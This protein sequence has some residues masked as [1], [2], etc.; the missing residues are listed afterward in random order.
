MVLSVT[1][2][3]QWTSTP[4]PALVVPDAVGAA[5]AAEVRARLEEAGYTRY[6]L[7][8]RGSYERSAD[9]NEWELLAALTG[10]A[11]EVTGRQLRLS[12]ARALRLHA[13][14][15]LLVRHD[16]VYEGSPVEI[17]LDL[18]RAPVAGADV[19]YRHRGQV[20]FAFASAPGA[21]SLVE[22]G[23]TVMCNHTYVSKLRGDAEVV[24]LIALLRDE[25]VS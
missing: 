19:H 17:V 7:F 24:R 2:R 14:D 1:F 12:E 3:D 15:Y 10:I 16:R 8:D 20:F 11:A 13:G 6:A 4:L 23:P 5:L 9:P 21:L 25:S 22:R 18:S